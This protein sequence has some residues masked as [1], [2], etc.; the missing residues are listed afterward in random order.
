MKNIFIHPRSNSNFH[1]LFKNLLTIQFTIYKFLKRIVFFK[2]HFIKLFLCRLYSQQD[3]F[4][5]SLPHCFVYLLRKVAFNLNKNMCLYIN[6]CSSFKFLLKILKHKKYSR[7]GPEL[8]IVFLV[9]L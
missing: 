5:L 7:L 8:I 4:H 3:F 9:V 1:L 2:V 6:M